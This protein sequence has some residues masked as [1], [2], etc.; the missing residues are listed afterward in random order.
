MVYFANDKIDIQ[1]MKSTEGL[2]HW[3]LVIK[4]VDPSDAGQYECQV[5][6]AQ[7]FVYLVQ[8]TVIGK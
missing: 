6:S 7:A 4:R 2:D 8:L 1:Q 5:P 3:N